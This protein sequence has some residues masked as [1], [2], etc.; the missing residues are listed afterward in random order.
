LGRMK[1]TDHALVSNSPII[2]VKPVSS[3]EITKIEPKQE[4]ILKPSYP[5]GQFTI[6]NSKVIYVNANTVWLALAEQYDIPLIR[7]WE[8]ND[9]EKSEDVLKNG[10]L[11]YLQ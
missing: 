4:M 9:L 3:S 8:F 6:N 11:I 1:E 5:T 7:L 2:P 10:Q